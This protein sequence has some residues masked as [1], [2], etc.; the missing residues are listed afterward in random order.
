MFSFKK[1]IRDN[2]ID[3]F[4]SNVHLKTQNIAALNDIHFWLKINKIIRETTKLSDICQLNNT[5]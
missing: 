5:K 2:I 3:H 1:K 4:I